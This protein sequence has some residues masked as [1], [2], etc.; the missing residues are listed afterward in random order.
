MNDNQRYRQVVQLLQRYTYEYHSLDRPTVSDAVYDSLVAEAQAYE[1]AHPGRLNP[2][3]PT[4]RVG[5]QPLTAF[6][7]VE[8][9][10]AMLSINHALTWDEV[11]A[12][13]QRLL[14]RLE[15]GTKLDY[16]V[17]FKMDGLALS[18]QYRRGR[19]WQA[20]TR[21]D[22]RTG[23][24][25]TAN[26]RTIKNLPLELPNTPLGRQPEL[27]VRGEVV[28]YKQAFES[29]NRRQA[30][31]KGPAYAN[32]RNLAAGTMRQLDSRIAA[33]RPLVFLA[34]DLL[35]TDT[36]D[37]VTVFQQLDELGI[38]HNQAAHLCPDLASLRRSLQRWSTDRQRQQLR[39]WADGLVIRVNNRQLGRQLGWVGKARRS[40][41]AYKYPP[42]EA[43]AVVEQIMLSIGRT[44]VVT[45]I[46]NFQPIQLAGTTIRHASLHNAD[47][48]DRLDVRVGDTV[49]IYKAGEIIPKVDRVLTELRPRRSRRFNFAAELRRQHPGKQFER[50]PEVVAYRL[51]SDQRQDSAQL[52]AAISH[53]GG[54]AALAID[55][56]GEE[57]AQRLVNSGLVSSLADIHRLELTRVVALE[58]MGE[59]SANQLL[60]AIAGSQRPPLGRFLFG[61]G[62]DHIGLVTA[63]LLAD[64]YQTLDKFVQSKPDDLMAIDGIGPKVAATIAGWLDRPANRQTLRDLQG[65]GVK[66]QPHQAPATDNG[67]LR[68]QKLVVSGRLK[69]WG[70]AAVREVIRDAGGQIQSSL[71]PR[72]DYLVIGD[73]PGLAKLARAKTL[74]VTVLTEAQ[75][76]EL[77]DTER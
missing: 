30:T 13:Q 76:I 31:A 6:R 43:T 29:F 24:E 17:D 14:D 26:A 21:G 44:G 71:G 5:D 56:L 64:H 55:G 51:T 23:E 25:V 32:P 54:R 16:F 67:R 70:R 60:A 8:H 42:T 46:A 57:T 12:W 15:D 4:Q 2:N 77:L 38:S 20:L 58:G 53:Y 33:R 18:L 27:E 1:D 62:I 34:Y 66:P 49:V 59:K 75:L 7:K 50:P 68:R 48:I 39:F 69:R 45:P 28:I 72:T 10:R 35:G 65:L 22:G 9:A 36:P 3:S 19:L 73:N 40:L 61:L 47:E 37:Q 52:V 74:G 11:V 41:L 63:R